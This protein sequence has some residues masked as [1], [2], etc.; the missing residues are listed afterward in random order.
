MDATTLQTTDHLPGA[1]ADA[2][3]TVVRASANEM[4]RDV[5]CRLK[6]MACRNLAR[7]SVDTIGTTELVHELYLRM[8]AN[9]ELHFEKPAQFFS[10]A[11]TAMRHFLTD[12]ARERL[13]SRNHWIRVTLG[14]GAEQVAVGSADEAV[15]I[16][17][18]IDRLE[19]I[20]P[21]AAKVFE[22]YLFAG[23]AQEQIG[24]V[25]GLARRTVNRDWRFARAFLESELR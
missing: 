25:L 22:L 13:R 4:F 9:R 17:D 24:E 5:Y 8:T 3:G 12:R 2:D 10:Y 6:A 16:N 18:A 21:R 23:L 11:A 19:A 7:R 15:Q 1:E 14:D 20:D